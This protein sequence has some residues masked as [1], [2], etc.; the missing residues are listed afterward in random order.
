MAR[1][2][3]FEPEVYY[4]TIGSH[5]PVLHVESGDT[6]ETRT[7]ESSGT[8]RAGKQVSERGN[9]QTGPF[10]VEG[11]EPGDVLA[12]RFDRIVPDR[13]YGRTSALVAHNVVDPEFIPSL[14]RERGQGRW[15]IDLEKWTATV[16]EPESTLGRLTI[17]LDPMLGCFGVA[18][19]R[20]QAISCATSAQHGGN[21]DYRGFR[22]GVT[23]YLPVFVPG[24]LFHLG[25]GHATQGDGEITGTGTEIPMEVTFT[26]WIHRKKQPIHW[27]RAEDDEFIMAVG[28]ARPLDQALQHATTELLR[29]LAE[30]Y[31]LDLRGASLLLGQCIRYDVGNVFDP[32]YTMVAK[33]EKRLV[34]A[35]RMG[36]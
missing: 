2:H 30:D 6:V 13:S 19:S 26:V 31:T 3:R 1:T 7:I 25:D 18:P 14:P 33:V 28:N 20:G 16:V 32:A 4:T 27:P 8:D 21:M 17:P 5:P 34:E 15:E 12:V 36:Q 10:Y 22:Q 29:W 11:A 9:P 24:A 23:V 35:Y